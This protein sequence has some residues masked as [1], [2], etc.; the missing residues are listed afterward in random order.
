MNP[1]WIITVFVIIDELLAK[2]GHAD[3][4]LAQVSDA[5]VLTVALVA[6]KW[7]P[8]IMKKERNT[9]LAS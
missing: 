2:G 1:L 4:R 5:E 7:V 8:V 6:A 9:S 3:H